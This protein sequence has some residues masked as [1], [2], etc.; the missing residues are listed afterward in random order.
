MLLATAAHQGLT[1]WCAFALCV[2]NFDVEHLSAL[3]GGQILDKLYKLV[4]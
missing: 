1:L 4:T 3:D 2:I